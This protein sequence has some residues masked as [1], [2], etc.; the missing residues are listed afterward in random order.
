MTVIPK[1]TI[2]QSYADLRNISCTKIFSK[3]YESY[4]LTW[5]QEEIELKPNQYGGTKGCSTAHMLVSLWDEICNNCEDY[6]AG[7]VLTAIDYSKAFNRVSFQH[8]LKAFKKKGASSNIIRLLATFLTNRTMV[9]KV[10][11]ARSA[12]RDVNGGCPQGSILGVFLFNVTTDD[13]EDDICPP[14]EPDPALAPST[15]P[16]GDQ[17]DPILSPP[18]DGPACSTPVTASNA[19]DSSISPLGGGRYR[20]KDLE[21]VFEAGARN[22]PIIEYSDEGL[23]TPPKELKTGTQVLV[24][25]EIVIAKYVDDNISVEKLNYGQTDTVVINGKK[26]KTRLAPRSQNAF[27]CITRRAWEKGM[28]VNSLKTQM[29]VVSDAVNYTPVAYITDRDGVR[30]ESTQSMKVLGFNFSNKPTMHAHVNAV[31]S[32]IRQKY[33]SLR[34]LRKVGFNQIELVE[35]YKTM[36]RPTAD[37]LDVVYHSLLTDEQDE[38]LENAQLGALRTIFDYKL[39]GRKLREKAGVETLRERRVKHCD[40]FAAKC[41]ASARFG[42]WFARNPDRVTRG[43]RAELYQE[44]FARC[45]RLKNSPLFFFRRRL[46]GKEGKQYGIRNRQFRE[47]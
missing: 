9:V 43:N 31:L 6:R 27:R 44:K 35:V 19:L 2:P 34:H 20:V 32:K 21:I 12:P 14:L 10:G 8:C 26:I 39:S 17:L 7:T 41:A 5:A 47:T 11:N 15:P 13:L 23:V 37:Y 30:I 46:N 4:V 42:P 40:S 25:K 33:W 38:A 29:L 28:L 36:I 1:K 3:L 24:D 18:A 45:D 16:S 22:L